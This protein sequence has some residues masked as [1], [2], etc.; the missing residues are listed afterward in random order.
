MLRAAKR[1]E[2]KDKKPTTKRKR[3]SEYDEESTPETTP[4]SDL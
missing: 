4:E 3:L 1:A 2:R